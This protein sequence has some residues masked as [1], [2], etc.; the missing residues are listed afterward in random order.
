MNYHLRN[1]LTLSISKDS[2]NFRIGSIYFK[3]SLRELF[4]LR[5]SFIKGYKYIEVT[6]LYFIYL[7]INLH[8]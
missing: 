3:D 1:L 5:I 4:E 6:F 2:F 7:C 8:W